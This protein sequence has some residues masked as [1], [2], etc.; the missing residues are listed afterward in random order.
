MWKEI[1]GSQP[2]E[3]QVSQ[4][5]FIKRTHFDPLVVKI[6]TEE[7]LDV[8][9]HCATLKFETADANYSRLISIGGP[10]RAQTGERCNSALA[11][12]TS[13]NYGCRLRPDPLY[14]SRYCY[15]YFRFLNAS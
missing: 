9:I 5:A 1:A 3:F 2:E 6:K 13:P 14:R 4:R 8:T 11:S 12:D 15:G 10:V 7:K